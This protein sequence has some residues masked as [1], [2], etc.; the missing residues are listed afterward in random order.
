MGAVPFSLNTRTWGPPPGPAPVTISS[1]PSPSTSHPDA[2]RIAVVAVAELLVVKAS[3]VVALTTAVL[4]IDRAGVAVGST[5]SVT[6]IE[7]LAPGAIEPSV[8]GKPPPHGPDADT[9]AVPAGA[10]S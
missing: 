3:A 2:R 9:K 5:F 8:H 6:V 10:G 4:V 1:T 7:A